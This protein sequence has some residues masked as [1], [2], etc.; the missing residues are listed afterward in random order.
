MPQ[1]QTPAMRLVLKTSS[2]IDIYAAKRG[3]N[4]RIRGIMIQKLSKILFVLTG[5]IFLAGFTRGEE[6]CVSN[7]GQLQNALTVAASN[8]E[9]DIIR[10]VRGTYIGNF[11]FDSKEGKNITLLGGFSPDCSSRILD[12]S[13]TI[14]DGDNA[15]RVLYINNHT[16]WENGEGSIYIKGFT[17]QNGIATEGG[18]I[19][20]VSESGWI[21]GN[22][23]IIKNVIRSNKASDSG[24]GLYAA[25]ESVHLAG[26]ILIKNNIIEKNSAPSWGGLC[27]WTALDFQYVTKTMNPKTNVRKGIKN[28]SHRIGAA[29]GNEGDIS[30]INNVVRDNHGGGI[31]AGT[32]GEMRAGFIS[33]LNNTITG[34]TGRGVTTTSGCGHTEIKGNIISGNTSFDQGGGVYAANYC[35]DGGPDITLANN[36]ITGNSSVEGGGVFARTFPGS[37]FLINNTIT[38]NLCTDSGGGILIEW[39]QWELYNNIIWGNSAPFGGDIYMRIDPGYWFGVSNGFNNDYASFHGIWTGFGGNIHSNP[40]FQDPG[41]GDFHLRRTSPCIDT[42]TNSAPRL[43]EDDF[44]SDPR[45]IDGDN[46]STATVDIGADEFIWVPLQTLTIMSSSGGST[47]PA[48]GEHVYV[49]GTEVTITALPDDH[50]RFSHWSGD[51]SG[52]DNPITVTMGADLSVTANFIRIIYSPSNFTGQKVLNR[53]LSQAEYINVLTWQANPNNVNI[54]QYRIYLVDGESKSL[55]AE[56]SANTFHYW[57]RRVER[58]KKYTYAICAVNDEDR[59]GDPAHITVQ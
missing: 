52:S 53:S 54:T 45:I 37:L 39:A 34:N 3:R 16:Y 24:G 46:D 43:P 1:Y 8:G 6:F 31:R 21:S 58:D 9:D 28:R 49:Q 44:D 42:G 27:A 10:V 40:Q 56:L 26:V 25:S 51:V 11:I 48:P 22:V 50:Y 4:P 59:E 19:Y 13:N 30:I 20:A 29:S 5:L 12:P 32:D 15:G 33:I 14:L 36:M 2:L 35:A 41:N 18:G 55:L 38:E 17:I 7:A 23:S 47:D 57:H